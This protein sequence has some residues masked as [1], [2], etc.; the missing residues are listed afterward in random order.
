MRNIGI[1]SIYPYIYKV[2]VRFSLLWERHVIRHMSPTPKRTVLISRRFFALYCI[3]FNMGF[4]WAFNHTAP[5]TY[6]SLHESRHMKLGFHHLFRST[7]TLTSNGDL[8]CRIRR[9]VTRR[10]YVMLRFRRFVLLIPSMP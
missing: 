6:G 10:I 9:I 4:Y 8:V 1:I 3:R 2:R 7:T 5:V